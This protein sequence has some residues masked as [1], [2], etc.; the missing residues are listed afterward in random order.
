MKFLLFLVVILF[1]LSSGATSF[2]I[3]PPLKRVYLNSETIKD[4]KIKVTRSI[5]DDHAHFRVHIPS[6]IDGKKYRLS[7]VEIYSGESNITGFSGE[8]SMATDD[9]DNTIDGR[10]LHFRLH[11]KLVTRADLRI[12]FDDTRYDLELISSAL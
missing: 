3:S 8:E 12:I 9:I 4:Y 7:Y 10:F 6:H 1:T 5:Y 11:K 2:I